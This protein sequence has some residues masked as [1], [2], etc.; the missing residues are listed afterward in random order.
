M[1]RVGVVCRRAVCIDLI[2]SATTAERLLLLLSVYLSTCL[3]HQRHFL[4]NVKLCSEATAHPQWH[5]VPSHGLTS[6]ALVI[7]CWT[8]EIN[9]YSLAR[10]GTESRNASS[11]VSSQ[12]PALPQSLFVSFAQIQPEYTTKSDSR[13]SQVLAFNDF[14]LAVI[15]GPSPLQKPSTID[16][17]NVADT[18]GTT[19]ISTMAHSPLV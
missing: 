19:T 2:G 15:P 9:Q 13:S 6:A 10:I 12:R 1:V 4:H 5:S 17:A 11:W 14:A 7:R 16:V 8:G 18:F 3:R